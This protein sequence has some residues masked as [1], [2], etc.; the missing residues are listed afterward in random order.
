MLLNY[1]NI[2]YNLDN[3]PFKY[4]FLNASLLIVTLS[5]WDWSDFKIYIA[6]FTD[7]PE[8]FCI[9]EHLGKSLLQLEFLRQNYPCQLCVSY[10]TCSSE[11]ARWKLFI[12]LVKYSNKIISYL[13]DWYMLLADFFLRAFLLWY[14][15]NVVVNIFT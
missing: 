1:V 2:I 4:S 13:S 15:K 7:W 9:H 6:Q 14:I 5:K 11:I 3:L 8:I 12:S 10:N